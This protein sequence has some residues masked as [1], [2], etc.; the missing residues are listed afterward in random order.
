MNTLRRHPTATAYLLLAPGVAYLTIFYLIPTV[1]MFLVSLWT[2]TLE[3]GYSLTFNF[4]IY[5]QALEQYG[6]HFTRSVVYGGIATIA[7]FV[8]G[9]PLAYF[10]AFRGG[11]YKNVLLFLVIAPFFTSFLLRTIAW[12]AIFADS[13]LALGPL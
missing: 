4:A 7:T 13:G 5:P 10:I 1:Q 8:I 3:T 2:G 9:F 6:E 11:R 12:Q